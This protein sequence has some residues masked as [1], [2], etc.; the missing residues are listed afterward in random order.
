MN[1]YFKFSVLLSSVLLLITD[2]YAQKKT[3]YTAKI[4]SLLQAQYPRSFNGIIL[5]TKKEKQNTRK[6]LALQ[7]W[8]PGDLLP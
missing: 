6:P 5:I 7:I 2:S 4:D 8:K 1:H 3:D